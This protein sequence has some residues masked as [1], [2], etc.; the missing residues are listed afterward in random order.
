MIHSKGILVLYVKTGNQLVVCFYCHFQSKSIKWFQC[1]VSSQLSGRFSNRRS[2]NDS[3]LP[4]WLHSVLQTEKWISSLNIQSIHSSLFH[5]Q[6]HEPSWG[7]EMNR[8]EEKWNLFSLL[9]RNLE[10]I[11]QLKLLINCS[12]YIKR[13][14]RKSNLS[15]FF[16]KQH[17]DV[18]G[19]EL[20]CVC[21]AGGSA[22]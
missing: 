10:L 7:H 6:V 4:V 3:L 14:F 2:G 15:F 18:V 21:S 8:T 5:L 19:G 16:S 20:L 22:E 9:S 1:N 17:H 13:K 11:M 12:H